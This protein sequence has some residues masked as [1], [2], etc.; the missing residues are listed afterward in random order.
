MK[1][2]RK[3]ITQDLREGRQTLTWGSR[4]ISDIKNHILNIIPQKRGP[5]TQCK[6]YIPYV[7]R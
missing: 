6:L 1:E 3:I 7:S 4:S 5:F 2:I